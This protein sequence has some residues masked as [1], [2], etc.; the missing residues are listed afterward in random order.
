M[1]FRGA[2]PT[3]VSS[4]RPPGGEV[5]FR[6]LT[7]LV[8]V[9]PI[10]GNDI[11]APLPI[12]SPSKGHLS[13]FIIWFCFSQEQVHLSCVCMC[14]C[15]CTSTFPLSPPRSRPDICDQHVST[16]PENSIHYIPGS[17]LETALKISPSVVFRLGVARAA[18]RTVEETGKGGARWYGARREAEYREASD[19]CVL[20]SRCVARLRR[21]RKTR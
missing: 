10:H 14:V 12:G 1:S 20:R 7:S 21:L 6:N 13:C 17:I 2:A 9:V 3:C 19:V 16:G 15:V 11:L 18:G 4:S 5:T 8:T